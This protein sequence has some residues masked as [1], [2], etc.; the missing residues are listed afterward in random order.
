VAIDGKA[1]TTATAVVVLGQEELSAC[2]RVLVLHSLVPGGDGR[3]DVAAHLLNDGFDLEVGSTRE[4]V[5]DQILDADGDEVFTGGSVTVLCAFAINDGAGMYAA[6]G[7]CG[8]Y[9]ALHPY[10]W[11]MLQK[12]IAQAYIA[13][14][15][16]DEDSGRRI[17]LA[18][19][20][21]TQ[22]WIRA[23]T[24][25][26]A[27]RNQQFM[28][29]QGLLAPPLHGEGP[30]VSFWDSFHLAVRVCLCT[31]R[32]IAHAIGGWLGAGTIGKLEARCRKV[33]S[34][35]VHFKVS[36]GWQGGLWVDVKLRKCGRGLAL[37]EL[38]PWLLG[39]LGQVLPAESVDK[40]APEM[41]RM[42]RWMLKLTHR[43]VL[44]FMTDDM[45]VF[46]SIVRSYR[47]DCIAL[48]NM[49][50]E[51]SGSFVPTPSAEYSDNV[52]PLVFEECLKRGITAHQFSMEALEEHHFRRTKLF[53]AHG[54]WG[55]GGRTDHACLRVSAGLA[56]AFTHKDMGA[57]LARRKAALVHARARMGTIWPEDDG[58]G[59]DGI[60]ALPGGKNGAPPVV[61]YAT[62]KFVIGESR[63][64][65][66]AVSEGAGTAAG[67]A[68]GE[69]DA[70]DARA[71]NLAQTME[72]EDPDST[73]DE[74]D[75]EAR[76]EQGE[77]SCGG[78]GDDDDDDDV[79]D[80]TGGRGEGEDEREGG[81]EREGEGTGGD[82]DGGGNG[83]CGWDQLDM[84]QDLQSAL[85][86]AAG[87]ARAPPRDQTWAVDSASMGTVKMGPEET[88][89][90]SLIV[91]GKEGRH[92]AKAV[93]EIRDEAAIKQGKEGSRRRL[94]LRVRAWA[95]FSYGVGTSGEV[96]D[97]SLVIISIAPPQQQSNVFAVGS[98]RDGGSK[99]SGQLQDD[100]S[101]TSGGS[102][103]PGEGT[104][105][106]VL[107]SATQPPKMSKNGGRVGFGGH[108][109]KIVEMHTAG[110]SG[111]LGSR[112]Q[113]TAPA[114][115]AAWSSMPPV[116]L[117][118]LYN[119]WA[120]RVASVLGRARVLG[121]YYRQRHHRSQFEQ[122]GTWGDV[123][124]PHRFWQ[125]TTG[126]SVRLIKVPYGQQARFCNEAG[127]ELD[128]DPVVE[129]DSVTG[130]PGT[131]AP[132]LGVYVATPPLT[133][134]RAEKLAAAGAHA[135]GGA[136]SSEAGPCT[137]E[138]C[139]V[140]CPWQRVVLDRLKWQLRLLE[141][142]EGGKKKEMIDRLEGLGVEA[143]GIPPV[144]EATEGLARRRLIQGAGARQK[145]GG[146]QGAPQKTGGKR[147]RA[148][149]GA[150][151]SDSDY[152]SESEGGCGQPAGGRGRR[153]GL[154]SRS[155]CPAAKEGGGGGAGSEPE[156]EEAESQQSVDL[157]QEPPQQGQG[158]QPRELS[159]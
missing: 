102:P 80:L 5:V 155:S 40:D 90:L 152:E 51:L 36:T 106:R 62:M 89:T 21:R 52:M 30:C 39:Q 37:V 116:S 73:M 91:A 107:I 134:A 33:L 105:L 20:Q 54:S 15:A 9:H 31:L 123:G 143:A 45:D 13:F 55:A 12:H 150:G 147:K 61:S 101:G 43:K 130:F 64:S 95:G 59:D 121:Q 124:S 100:P 68:A 149:S 111:G 126:E 46:K 98:S 7:T 27:Y 58:C 159:Y 145:A 83:L 118:H 115:A 133:K 129:V 128:V 72:L 85:P 38:W 127:H 132:E 50:S 138:R 86:G 103:Q 79:V 88:G 18:S 104:A 99:G 24:E 6:M 49:I 141:K 1:V 153:Q 75:A 22:E 84:E 60:T 10:C 112:Q 157:L 42:F 16:E 35:H 93:L 137:H 78:D 34:V 125:G 117:G 3:A 4:I 48:A 120:S 135:G 53:E 144:G 14:D 32:C 119:D 57:E 151:S 113:M 122:V 110:G 77:E 154:R 41:M 76:R 65:A 8:T 71:L 146:K 28:L 66:K 158:P 139:R 81:G 2:P 25:S 19:V 47:A 44:A 23:A 140:D 63:S 17:I 11:T 92:S 114:A 136:A 26:R 131:L 69:V 109:Q 96:V 97:G 56:D 148:G 108:L 87:P 82:G 94:V 67:E 29:D 156:S 142:R 74:E 70:G